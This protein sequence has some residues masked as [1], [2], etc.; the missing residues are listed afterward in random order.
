MEP[1][2]YVYR[3]NGLKWIILTGL[4]MFLGMLLIF[5]Q[6]FGGVSLADEKALDMLFWYDQ[7]TF[8]TVLNSLSKTDRMAYKLIHIA[9]YIFIIGLYPLLS[10]GISRNIKQINWVRYIVLIPLLAG[11]FD[12]L[13]NIAM[14]VHLYLYPQQFYIL[15]TC[16][17]IFSTAKFVALL[18]AVL[19]L[20][21]SFSSRA[22]NYFKST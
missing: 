7:E 14:D 5:T 15:G 19:L 12:V 8:Y 21:V 4:L 16:A 13:E 1:S 20:V 22:I 18:F 17:G 3:H 11:V 9:D 2:Q 6:Y 10:I